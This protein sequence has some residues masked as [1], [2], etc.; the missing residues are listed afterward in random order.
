MSPTPAA[1]ANLRAMVTMAEDF[2]RPV[3]YSDH[4]LG[5]HVAVAAVALGA[6]VAASSMVRMSSWGTVRS[7][8]RRTLRLFLTVSKKSTPNLRPV[9]M[10]T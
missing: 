1:A 9:S 10:T 2:A 8:K 7:L 6:C 5:D 3:G 4:T